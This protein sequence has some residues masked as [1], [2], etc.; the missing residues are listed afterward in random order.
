MLSRFFAYRPIFAWV[1]AIVVMAAGT[2]AVSTMGVEQFP[3]IAPP[4][5]SVSANYPGADAQTIENSVTQVLEQQLKG[6]DGLLYF[7]ST[8]NNGQ[9]SITATFD[10][11]VNPDTAQVQVQNVL[12]RALTRLPTQVQA[13]GLTV[14]KSQSDFLLMLALSDTTGKSDIADI[15]DYL[16]IH[17][18]DPISRL[19]GVG[20]ADVFGSQYA[21]R[22]WLDPVKLAA[23]GLMPSDVNNAL[24]AQNTQVSAGEVGGQPSPDGQ[25]LNAT[26]TARSRLQTIDQFQNLILKTTVD[27]ATVRLKDVARVEMGMENYSSISRIDGN[28]AV[29]LFA[30][31]ASGANAMTTAELIKAKVTELSK[32]LPPG[33]RIDYPRDSS[34]FVKISINE[35]IKTLFEAIVLVVIVMYVFLQ[36]WRATL[37]PAIAVPV[38]LL[39]TFGVLAAVGYTMNTLT[40]FGLVLAIGLLVDDAIVVVENVERVMAEEHLSPRDATIKSMGEITSA[41]IG[42]TLVLSAVF[43]PMAFFGGSTGVIY[44]QFSVT[45]VSA[46]ALSVAVALILTPALCATLLKHEEK[47]R[48]RFFRAFNHHYDRA[49]SG[50]ESRLVGFLGRPLPWLAVFAGITALALWLDTRLPTSFLPDEDQGNMNLSFTLPSGSTLE[51]TR[52]FALK[53]ADYV[54][55]AESANVDH[56]FVAVGRSQLQGNGQNI[57][58]GWIV[59]KPWDERV[60]AANS[61]DAIA[62]RLNKHFMQEVVGQALVIAPPA[63]RGLGNSAGFEMWL[64]DASGQGADALTAARKQLTDDANADKQ[65]SQVRFGGLENTPQVQVDLNDA[66]ATALQV[67]PSDVNST[68]ATAWGG[69]YVNDFVDRGRVKKVYVQGD[70]PFRASPSDLGTWQVRGK[71]GDMVPLSALANVGWTSGPLLL[72]RFNGIPAQQLQGS[73]A[74]GVSSGQAMKLMEAHAAQLNGGYDVAWSGLSYQERSSSSKAPLL[75]GASIFFIFLCLAALYES[76]TVPLSVL[77]VIPLGVIGAVL[78]VTLRGFANDIYFQVALLTTIG[79]SAKNAILIVEFAEFGMQRGLSAYEA[80]RDAAR[81]RFRPIMMTSVA[82]IAG[83][84][85]LA[86]A[87]GAGANGREAI[88]TAVLGG[89]ISAT[90]LAIF[91]VPLFFVSVKRWLGRKPRPAVP[92]QEATA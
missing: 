30:N 73:G 44:R 29:G 48:H 76:W 79:L 58:Q 32:D 31:L 40:M 6:I 74:A 89:M 56:V 60:G 68:I 20:N 27:G 10:K 23:V 72:R 22:I 36:N 45:I 19:P 50:Y 11:S 91:F 38:V 13:Q 3:D 65:L 16:A 4:T 62:K 41:L 25:R 69:T 55:K 7:T 71:N 80:A 92:G 57:G 43:I 49:Q 67:A 1:L 34:T 39:G 17:M 85:P 61:A 75:F 51:Q 66:A 86:I 52:E 18:L 64:Q 47:P 5:I 46:M 42:I 26:I 54:R 33:Y 77:L 90:V 88:G 78:A 87:S 2:Y 9:A 81:M 83:V 14:N 21:M 53:A 37:I 24:L 70:A 15:A 59:L 82:F 84:I 63:I 12:Q 8:S 28:P 35:V